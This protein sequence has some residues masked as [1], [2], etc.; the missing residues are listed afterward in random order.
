MAKGD[1]ESKANAAAVAIQND[2]DSA[3]KALLK[4]DG[5]GR[6]ANEINDLSPPDLRAAVDD[7]GLL[8]RNGMVEELAL[9]GG[10]SREEADEQTSEE[11]DSA[12]FDRVWDSRAKREAWQQAGH[13]P[14]DYRGD[15]IGLEEFLL[16]RAAELRAADREAAEQAVE[17]SDPRAG[18]DYDPSDLSDEEL[19]A[20]VADFETKA[21]LGEEDNPLDPE[22]IHEHQ[23]GDLRGELNEL[24]VPPDVTRDWSWEELVLELERQRSETRQGTEPPEPEPES[25]GPISPPSPTDPP[26]VPVGGDPPP[27]S[28]APRSDP[29][30]GGG[31]TG[32]TPG[33]IGGSEPPDSGSDPSGDSGSGSGSGDD[34]G[35]AGE[36]SG[37]PAGSTQYGSPIRDLAG[38][39]IGGE[40]GY[41]DTD[42]NWFDSDGSPMG[43]EKA[44]RMEE[45]YKKG[46]LNEGS[47]VPDDDSTADDTAADDSATDDSTTNDS[48]ADA[49][50][51]ELTPVDPD[52][53]TSEDIDRYRAHIPD[54]GVTPTRNQG[55]TDP[56]DP[57]FDDGLGSGEIR[58]GRDSPS[59]PSDEE[60]GGMGEVDEDLGPE[61]NPENT[62]VPDDEFEGDG[63]LENPGDVDTT[64]GGL[65]LSDQVPGIVG[66]GGS[67]GDETPPEDE[68]PA[69]MVEADV[70]VSGELPL[71]RAILPGDYRQVETSPTRISPEKTDESSFGA[72]GSNEPI[73]RG[74]AIGGDDLTRLAP[75]PDSGEA[76]PEPDSYLLPSL[77]TGSDEEVVRVVTPDEPEPDIEWQPEEDIRYGVEEESEL[78]KF[79]A[80]EEPATRGSITPLIDLPDDD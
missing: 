16:H 79:V 70:N 80:E 33:D 67:T 38:N 29:P 72:G 1:L 25:D 74:D 8:D 15:E 59:D 2:K 3:L 12:V 17:D 45:R 69:V 46:E 66:D 78:E 26:A 4:Q 55:A 64:P 18:K 21:L 19:A 75:D 71:G 34:G 27:P 20:R 35:T 28:G 62:R 54:Q 58:W 36:P 47:T 9:V 65:D 39:V 44:E 22:T 56:S 51:T 50:D 30:S 31:G 60:S 5:G 40:T 53:P 52:A 11:P 23:K 57:S 63:P 37:P 6:T 10:V 73:R 32:G 7:D 41:R 61:V 49:A 14:A 77:A 76:E 43:S 42:G 13:E 68:P 48:T 24:G